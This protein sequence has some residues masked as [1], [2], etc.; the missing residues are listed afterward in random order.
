MQT[1][2]LELLTANFTPNNLRRERLFGREFIVAPLTM[3]I[4]GVLNGSKGPLY[5]PIDE[6]QATV[7]RW[8]G[9]PI[10]VNHPYDSGMPVSARSPGVL[11]KYGIGFVFNADIND[12]N[13][14]VAEGWFDIN[15]LRLVDNRILNAL[16]S[17]R[18]MELSTGLYT[19]NESKEGTFNGSQYTGIARNYRPD[20]LAILPDTEGACSLRDGCGV[21]VN[22]K[23]FSGDSEMK[24]T[25]EQRKGLVDGLIANCDCKEKSRA[26]VL[27]GI[28]SEEDRE[29]L[30][31]FSDEKLT[32]L[33][34][35]RKLLSINQKEE[36]PPPVKKTSKKTETES[37]SES[38]TTTNTVPTP[39]AEPIQMTAEQWFSQAPPEVQA[40]LN[41]AGQILSKQ[42]QALVEKIVANKRN[43]FT[44]EY[45]MSKTD[46]D[47]L[48]AIAAL[49]QEPEA[50]QAPM[51]RFIGQAAPVANLNAEEISRFRDEDADMDPPTI[52]WAEFAAKRA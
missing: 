3:I 49:A 22:S 10:V 11:D 21:N 51:S 8:N 14:L 52:N 17:S 40:T 36:T 7:E 6:I 39:P 43:T 45:L 31:G 18:K 20:H 38:V 29:T 2:A 15:L 33:T 47:E 46:I 32:A 48:Q 16:N 4:S 34:E 42:K 27:N 28:W 26:T 13:N 41:Y 30:E 25:A 23:N 37:G 12:K 24:L 5:Y 9:M 35:Q 19:T 44:R 50:P 1:P